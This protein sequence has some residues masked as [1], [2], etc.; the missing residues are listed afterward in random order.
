VE[1]NEWRGGV[2]VSTENRAERRGDSERGNK[3]CKNAQ[4]T[5]VYRLRTKSMD[6]LTSPFI[7][8]AGLAATDLGSDEG[9]RTG[10][11]TD[12]VDE[13]GAEFVVF[14]VCTILAG[15][16]KGRPIA[17]ASNSLNVGNSTFSLSRSPPSFS[18]SIAASPSTPSD[19]LVLGSGVCS[20]EDAVV[21]GR[22]F[23]G[24]RRIGGDADLLPGIDPWCDE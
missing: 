21:P 15:G 5:P 11:F 20:M 24:G 9:P 3:E 14:V 16:S 8:V 23:N 10:D 17:A 6:I 1:A 13:G 4:R 2:V 19:S 7:V 12:T 18:T 22:L